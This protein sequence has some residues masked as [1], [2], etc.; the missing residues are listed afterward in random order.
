MKDKLLLFTKYILVIFCIILVTFHKSYAVEEMGDYTVEIKVYQDIGN[1]VFI[2][3]PVGG[4]MLI[5]T[6]RT[7]DIVSNIIQNIYRKDDFY[8][9]MGKIGWTPRIDWL[10]ISNLSPDRISNVRSIIRDFNVKNLYSSTDMRKLYE[11]DTIVTKSAVS[12][13]LYELGLRDLQLKLLSAGNNIELH[14]GIEDLKIKVLYPPRP[15]VSYQDS[16]LCLKLIYNDVKIMYTSELTD[17]QQR[18]LINSQGGELSSDILIHPIGISSDFLEQVGANWHITTGDNKS[19][20]TDGNNIKI[21]DI[22]EE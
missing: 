3:F 20:I 7:A 2:T 17:S 1:A 21:T 22:Q 13:L 15:A 9:F 6:G 12:D 18:M 5:D 14:Q 19:I 10:I 8:K 16:N 11:E 4:T